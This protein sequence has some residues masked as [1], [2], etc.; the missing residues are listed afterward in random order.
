MM[1]NLNKKIIIIPKV[2]VCKVIS[3]NSSKIVSNNRELIV[4][5]ELG[6]I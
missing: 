3:S 6:C 2:L 1:V 4:R 5:M